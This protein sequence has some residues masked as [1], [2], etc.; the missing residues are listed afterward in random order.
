MIPTLLGGESLRRCLASLQRQTFQGFETVVVDNS[1]CG[2]AHGLADPP[3][4]R[5]IENRE[6][7]GF[8]EAV[9]QGWSGTEAEFLL[10]LN[11][12]AYPAPDWLQALIAACERDESI[13]MCASQIRLRAK[14]G[15]LDSA[16]MSIYPDGMAKQRGNG[17]PASE[18]AVEEEVLLPSGCAALYRRA[19]VEQVG[20]FDAD[21]FLYAED[22]D[23]GLRGRLAGWRCLYVPRAEVEHDYSASSGRASG[24]KVFY[25]ERNRLFTVVKLFPAALW[26]LVPLISAWRYLAH[27]EAVARGRGL[28]GEFNGGGEK[29]PRLMLIVG[30]AYW[31]TLL[32]FPRLLRKRRAAREHITYGTIE[33]WR[34][35]RR[36]SARARDVA[37]Q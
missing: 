8:G 7:V 2:V 27:L 10:T 16:G 15:L 35:I 23:L 19:M 9:N 6:N 25:V 37:F 11:D 3:R 4:V 22:T 12:D 17:R 31:R 29:W 24:R 13:G 34:L 18:F 5:V 1:G 30:S 20:A 36:H 21:Y 32:Q 28:A 14:K 33:F 26:P